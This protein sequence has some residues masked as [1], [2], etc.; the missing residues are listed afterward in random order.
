MSFT[1]CITRFNRHPIPHADVIQNP[2][3]LFS[4]VP[5][6]VGLLAITVLTVTIAVQIISSSRHPCAREGCW[7]LFIPSCRLIHTVGNE[8]TTQ[9]RAWRMPT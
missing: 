2:Y 8:G 5:G 6:T 1:V 4:V 9:S 7:H 3:S